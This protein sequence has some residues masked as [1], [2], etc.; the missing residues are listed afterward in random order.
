MMSNSEQKDAEIY[1]KGIVFLVELV[2]QMEEG[3][4]LSR[5]EIYDLLA[6]RPDFQKVEDKSLKIAI[7]RGVSNIRRKG[8]LE[9]TRNEI[10]KVSNDIKY[11]TACKIKLFPKEDLE[12]AI[13][14]YG[15][16]LQASI[17]LGVGEG[18]LKN[19]AHK[20]GLDSPYRK[21]KFLKV[22]ELLKEGPKTTSEIWDESDI[23]NKDGWELPSKTLRQYKVV[24]E[25]MPGTNEHIYYLP[26]HRKIAKRRIEKI[27][28]MRKE[29]LIEYLKSHPDAP[30]REVMRNRGFSMILSHFFDDKLSNA[31][32]EADVPYKKVAKR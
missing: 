14:Q 23:R 3:E 22:M 20:Y 19:A 30:Y 21:Y 7:S 24:L 28:D 11:I 1:R 2:K 32:E 31:K 12:E 18:A 4:T 17:K 9:T 15:S 5:R 6:K 10:T 25:K 29:R 27:V 26:K 13:N 16:Y 8:V